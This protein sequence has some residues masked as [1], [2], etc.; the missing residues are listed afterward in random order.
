MNN[1]YTTQAALA[2]LLISSAGA[3]AETDLKLARSYDLGNTSADYTELMNESNLA[4]LKVS[5][6]LQARYQYNARQMNASPTPFNADNDDTMGFSIRRAKIGIEGKVTEDISGKIKFAFSRSSGASSLEAAYAKWK[7]NDDVTLKIG[8]FKQALIRE[9]NV[10]S[11]KQLAS[12]RSAVNETFN[13]SFSQGVEA[14]FGGDSW[15]GMVGFTDGFGAHNTAFNSATEADYALNGRVEFLFGDAEWG[16]FK[17]FTSWRGSNAGGMIGAAIAFQNMG[18]TNP[19]TTPTTEMTT[20][21]LDVSYVGDGWNVFAAGIWRNMD[22]GATTEADD[23]GVVVQGGIFV[24][25]QDELFGRWDG[26]FPDSS[27]APTDDEFNALTV[28]WNHY[29]I[30]ESH[31]AKFTLD[32]NYYLDATTTSIVSTS[33]SGGH[34][35]LSDADDGQFAVTAQMQILF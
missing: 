15:R 20:G 12:E 31:A 23:I 29:L 21:T 11:S 5:V 3:L 35:L 33:S 24:T 22:T 28:G 6:H 17:Q 30:P 18:D 4:E 9:E 13:Q 2:A 14:Q 32:F 34:N 27:N 10:S 26:V 7:L 8:Q 16:Q 19:A 25:D 1:R